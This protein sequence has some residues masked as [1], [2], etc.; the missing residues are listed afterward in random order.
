MEITIALISAGSALL[1]AIV[2]AAATIIP[3]LG[4]ERRSAVVASR[5]DM[6]GIIE[7]LIDDFDRGSNAIKRG[8]LKIDF[9][10]GTNML[11][12]TA[13]L[14]MLLAKGDGGLTAATLAAFNEARRDPGRAFDAYSVVATHL[15]AW[16]RKDITAS[17]Y[18]RIVTEFTAARDP[19]VETT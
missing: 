2:G 7:Q 19:R 15:P 10:V 9:E 6:R 17:E 18:E 14:G 3:A 4:A 11:H 8:D 12:H 1:G 5:N 16:F 13:K